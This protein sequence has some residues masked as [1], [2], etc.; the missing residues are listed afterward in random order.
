MS[1]DFSEKTQ[2]V[3][4][5]G[6][7][8]CKDCGGILEF[9]PGVQSM[10]CIYCGT[11][12]DLGEQLKAVATEEID[13]ESFLANAENS[14]EKMEATIVKCDSCGS[15]TTLRPNVTA[16]NC[17]FCGTALVLKGGTTASFIK[18]KYLLPFR[19]DKNKG[20]EAFKK[21][22]SGLWFAP[23]DLKNAAQNDKLKGLY[24]PYWTY[25]SDT[26]SKYSG[27]RG[28]HYYVSESYTVDGKTQ[29]RQVRKTRWTPTSGN[30]NDKF[31]DILVMASASLPEKLAQELEPWDLKELAAFNEQ[32]LTGFVAER[33][34][35]DVKQGF[36]KAKKRMEEIIRSTV[37]KHIGGDEQQI[38]TLNT[39]Y[40]KTTFKHLLLPIWLSAFK[41]SNKVYRFMINARTG[42]VQGERPYSFWKI[43]GTIA[44]AVAVIGG[45]I[46]FY[47]RYKHG[48]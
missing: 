48:A 47:Y 34:Q 10:K 42:E 44:G 13:F 12:N 43:F 30:V 7:V 39:N 33:Y 1:N 5:Q 35:T 24:I 26:A 25:D 38:L 36:E 19:I 32:L 6:K 4:E 15:S 37:K 45:A 18:P 41:Y 27:M 3:A 46:Y 14:A 28:D 16:D 17:P 21:W 11:Q 20:M 2:D 31:D 40:N 9:S 29:T 8:K 23:G 22:L